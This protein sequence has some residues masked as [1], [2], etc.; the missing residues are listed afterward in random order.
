MKPIF[1]YYPPQVVTVWA[2]QEHGFVYNDPAELIVILCSRNDHRHHHLSQP[3]D[4]HLV[5]QLCLRFWKA[6]PFNLFFVSSFCNV[7]G[8]QQCLHAELILIHWFYWIHTDKN[9]F[10]SL[11]HDHHQIGH[12]A[13]NSNVAG[14]GTVKSSWLLVLVPYA[15]VT[16]STQKLVEACRS[17]P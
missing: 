16:F 4:A 8:Q 5:P 2:W 13:D 9:Q 3:P 1:A 6:Y 11:W 14:D 7:M 17:R 10:L 15:A 12:F